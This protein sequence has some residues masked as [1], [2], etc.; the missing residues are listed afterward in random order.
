MRRLCRL[1][2][3][4][5]GWSLVLSAPGG[6]AAAEGDAACLECHAAA[7]DPALAVNAT[8][9][10]ASVHGEAGLSCTDCHTELAGVT[11]F[12]HNPVGPPACGSC[13][14]DVEKELAAS[15][16]KP[17]AADTPRCWTCH[18]GHD[19]VRVADP[20]SPIAP[21][22][23]PGTCLRCHADPQFA[24]THHKLRQDPEAFKQSV[25]YKR[26]QGG[27]AAPTCASCHGG[28]GGLS[29][30]D[31]RSSVARINVAK[32]CG[33]C[34]AAIAEQY[35]ASIHGAALERGNP[36]TPTC[37]TCH[38]EHIIRSR[39]DPN[40]PVSV[41]NIAATC[42]RCHDDERLAKEY[43]FAAARLKTF[44]GSFHGVAN[45]FGDTSVA[46]CASCHGAHDI[47]P[48]SD[49]RSSI[50]PSNLVHTCGQCHPQA[51]Q[52]FASGKIHVADR[53]ED[54]FWAWLIKRLYLMMIY[55]II[56]LFVFLI[57]ADLWWR[58]R[59]RRAARNQR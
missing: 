22:N 56:S 6:A 17:T 27:K 1:L 42:S 43:G 5:A 48:S 52:H 38:A 33:K 46:N 54:N 3:L 39:E 7:D 25:H 45:R 58:L 29:H 26:L 31:D 23:Q 12:P 55:S 44:I 51:G 28:H 8:I 19:L 4:A 18:G 53:P 16:H 32:T 40:S 34:H 36:D 49:P 47:L 20:R 21:L 9:L 59:R 57:M 30:L 14:S 2:V 10:K 15:E 13:H 37:N 35:R 24:R 41:F 50:H 11:E